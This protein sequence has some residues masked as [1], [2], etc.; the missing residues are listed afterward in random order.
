MKN[1]LNS[2]F[3]LLALL[4]Q[5]KTFAQAPNLFSYQAVIRNSS[6]QLIS[7]Q[8]IGVRISILQ[9]SE[10]GSIIYAETQT[11]TTNPNGLITI[12]VGAGTIVNGSLSAID[13]ANGPYFIK[14]E[15]DPAGGNAYSIFSTAQLL[16]VPY[17][18]YSAFSGSSIPGP[19]GE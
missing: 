12:Q 18:L 2:L 5:G 19:Q 9:G 1:I 3:I 16:S 8:Q 17:A 11:P 6:N 4:V 15:T 14:S 13:W 7:N 10:S